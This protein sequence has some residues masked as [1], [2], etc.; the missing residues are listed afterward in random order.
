MTEHTFRVRNA[1]AYLRVLA[2]RLVY[3]HEKQD[4]LTRSVPHPSFLIDEIHAM[5]WILAQYQVQRGYDVSSVL[6]EVDVTH[7]IS[8][9]KY[10]RYVDALESSAY[11]NRES[12]RE[13]DQRPETNNTEQAE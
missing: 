6:N 9:S 8:M 1:K 7:R 5:F 12:E 4:T 13:T 3:L 2:K 10:Q 11:W